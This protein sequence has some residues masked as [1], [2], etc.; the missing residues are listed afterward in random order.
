VNG[1]ELWLSDGTTPGTVMV[2]DINPGATGSSPANLT[3]FG[4]SLFFSADDG[5]NGLELWIR[6]GITGSTVM[7]MAIRPGPAGSD[8]G[9]FLAIGNSL[10]LSADDGVNGN[11]LWAG[12]PLAALTS[13]GSGCLGSNGTPVLSGLA[14]Q[15]PM[16][17]N[18]FFALEVQNGAA[19][20][21][22]YWFLAS[23]AQP[24]TLALP[25]GCS[26]HLELTSLA[27][28]FGLGINPFLVLPTSGIGAATFSFPIPNDPT[29]AGYTAGVQ[30]GIT[31]LTT[32]SGFTVTNALNV[33]IGN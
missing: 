32:P 28:L 24:N 25:G 11:E 14:G 12:V 8:L 31:D 27:T 18:N 29:L 7:L 21:A 17:G 30:V 13:V 10:F 6:N 2:A 15:L 4:N 26:V 20:S 3:A 33:T 16:I 22:S 5:T 1:N 19:N 9:N 23:R